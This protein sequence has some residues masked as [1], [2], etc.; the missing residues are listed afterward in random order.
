MSGFGRREAPRAGRIRESRP[1]ISSPAERAGLGA[2]DPRGPGSPSSGS[3]S[4]PVVGAP[5]R[6]PPPPPRL[7]PPPRTTATTHGDLHP[8][9][10][11]SRPGAD[12]LVVPARTR[13]RPLRRGPDRHRGHGQRVEPTPGRAGACRAGLRLLLRLWNGV[14]GERPERG[15]EDSARRGPGGGGAGVAL[16]FRVPGVGTDLPAGDPPGPVIWPS[17]GPVGHRHRL[18]EP[19]PGVAGLPDPRQRRTSGH[20]HRPFS[21]RGHADHPS[22]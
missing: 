3:C 14:V 8:L 22:P 17:R 10:R 15:P 4:P 7:L 12:R 5:H 21:R 9:R 20:F 19:G 11:V 18:P 1:G 16:L 2:A 6:S 13:Q